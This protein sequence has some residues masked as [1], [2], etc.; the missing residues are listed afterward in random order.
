MY[1]GKPP[2]VGPVDPSRPR[3]LGQLTD[4]WVLNQFDWTRSP[5]YESD[6]DIRQGLKWGR[7][8]A[9]QLRW[10]K[11]QMEFELTAVEKRAVT[12]YYFRGLNFREAALLLDVNPTSIYRAV[13]RAIC[14][15]RVAAKDSPWA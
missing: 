11:A 9:R 4:P 5:W 6:R 2:S 13:Q 8:K 3:H 1:S 15:L 14:K 7:K 12:L 10:V